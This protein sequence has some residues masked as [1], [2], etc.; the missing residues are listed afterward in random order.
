MSDSKLEWVF[1]EEPVSAAAERLA[2]LIDAW[3]EGARLA[4][5]GGSAAKAIPLVAAR[6]RCWPRVRL[7]Y[8]DERCV[9]HESVDSNRG[10]ISRAG[11]S[12]GVAEDLPLYDEGTPAEAAARAELAFRERF[13]AGLDFTLLGM[14][15]DGHIA[16]L[17]PGRPPLPGLVAGVVDSPKPPPERVT[18]TLAALQTARTHVLLAVGE[19]KREALGR[20]RADEGDSPA[21]ALGG[22]VVVTD[23]V[24]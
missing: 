17:F 2:G 19:S 4:V 7:T 8:T 12:V 3:G 23:L 1:S 10:E 18:Y 11:W 21:R 22:L 14:G 5:A 6:A 20:L 13:G 15:P 9:P 24:F 16:S